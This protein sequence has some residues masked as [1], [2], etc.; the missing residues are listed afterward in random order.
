MKTHTLHYKILLCILICTHITTYAQRDLRKA[1]HHKER[2]EYALALEHFNTHFK[3]HT[4]SVENKRDVAET[5]YKINDIRSA[6]VWMSKVVNS[7]ASTAEDIL[8][9]AHLLR[10]NGKY[11]KAISHY[12]T[13]I[14]MKPAEKESVNKWIDASRNAVSWMSEPAFFTVENATVFNST[15]ADFGILPFKDGFIVTTD[16][17][18][19]HN[20]DIYGWTGKPFLKMYHF[21]DIDFE[22]NTAQK[23]F[24]EDL[25]Y[26]Y[27]NGPASFDPHTN[28]LYFTR[29]K[30][31]KVRKSPM[32][33][34]P[35]S[36]IDYGPKES[37]LISRLEIYSA[38]Y[39]DGKWYDIK[40]FEYNNADLYSV[41]HP[42]LSPCGKIMY[43]ASDMPG[44]YGK[45]DIFYSVLDDEGK[46][47]TPQNAG[48]I[49]NTTESELFPYVAEDGTLYFSSNGHPGMGGLDIFKAT[50]SFANWSK[51]INMK[52]PINSP[53]DDFSIIFTRTDEQGFLA[54]NRDGGMG[55]DDI[56]SFQL[57][58]PATL[59]IA[60]LTKAALNNN[61]TEV[62]GNV[63]LNIETGSKQKMLQTNDKGYLFLDAKCSESYQFMASKDGYFSERASVLTECAS[64]SD[65]IYVEMILEKYEVGQ[66]FVIKNIFYDFDKWDIR[67]D[68]K[69]E[70]DN[71]V[72]ILTENPRINIELG[73]HTDSRGTA[74]YNEVLS[75]RRA[76]SA[77]AYIVSR[78]I[79]PS[80]ITAKGYGET[81]LVN[82]CA[83]G[84]RCTE[85]QHQKN[86]R[87]EFK[88]TG[89]N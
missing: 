24:L 37:D 51:P 46:W 45:T 56:Y 41:G 35:T 40:P 11:D 89:I 58:P 14:T 3:N 74:R 34:D 13:Y 43:F 61:T 31:V 83:E 19:R 66:T 22:K 10:S 44:S 21:S 69:P 82:H 72:T 32:N 47:G 33:T 85:E 28:T 50:G 88:I 86:R 77:V 87:T 63:N 71:I 26:D 15:H 64:Y 4:P 75:Q 60:A 18:S 38:T 79:D 5:Y 55:Y 80:R 54:S 27:H 29:T 70:L 9:Y 42:A 49:I 6:E 67:E 12:E 81:Q 68:A 2:F 25:N 52:Y 76:E 48:N 16:R 30:L 23:T 84:V 59:I 73:S 17:K 57:K 53:K 7:E 65:T 78:G 36:W 1:H 62:L 39:K 8:N 20:S